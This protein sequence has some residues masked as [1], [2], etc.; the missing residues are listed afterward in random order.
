[1]T[2][3]EVAVSSTNHNTD[4]QLNIAHEKLLQWQQEDPFFKRIISLL[5]S[6]KLQANNP[7]YMEDELLMR[8]IINNKQCF[9]IMVL[10]CMLATRILR[11]VHEELGY[12]GSTRICRLYYWK[13]L[14]TSANK[15][16]KH[17]MI[18]QKRNIQVVKYAQLHFSTPG[19]QMQFMSMDLICSFDLPV[20]GIIML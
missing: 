18:C 12:Y 8:N 1:M 3:N 2:L 5:K 11:A 15:H 14:K 19:L 6:S 10:S 16:I 7:Y 20:V 13:D 9:H 4:V 17:F